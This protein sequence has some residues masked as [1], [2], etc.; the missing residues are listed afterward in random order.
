MR[1]HEEGCVSVVS[2]SPISEEL[3]LLSNV[4]TEEM[5]MLRTDG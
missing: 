5:K 2:L 4:Y 3:E 1:R